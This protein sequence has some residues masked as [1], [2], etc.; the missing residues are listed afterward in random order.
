[1]FNAIVLAGSGKSDALTE[2]QGVFNKA[3]IEIYRKTLLAYIIEALESSES[4]K[5]IIVVGPAEDLETLR[6]KGFKFDIVAEKE[7]MLENLAAGFEIIERDSLCLIVTGDIPL[8]TS[9]VIDRFIELCLPHDADLY[10]PVLTRE[11]CMEK[12]PKNIRTYVRLKEGY[13]TGGN[14]ALV[15]SDWY[16]KNRKRLEMF[17]SYRKKPLKLMR[18]LPLIL[19]IKY[20]LKTLSLVDL[21]KYLSKLMYLK[22]KAVQCDCVEVGIDVDKPSDL[23]LVKEILSSTPEFFQLN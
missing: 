8:I 9:K 18:I 6:Q 13:L 3:F 5:K 12:Y 15:R 10:Y 11:T 7:S 19:I 20:F 23:D 21:E 22:A 14:V 17:V 16:L 4:V 2:Q 1:M